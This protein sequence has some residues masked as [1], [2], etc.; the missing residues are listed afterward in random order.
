M[1]KQKTDHERLYDL[2]KC[3]EIQ[4]SID[5]STSTFEKQVKISNG[6]KIN[7]SLEYLIQYLIDK[8]VT[9]PPEKK[10]VDKAMKSGRIKCRKC[11]LIKECPMGQRVVAYDKDFTM[12]KCTI[13]R[14]RGE[15][16]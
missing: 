10:T 11:D 12:G 4:E 14:V 3:A 1:L 9:L 15:D 2:I 13:G 6:E 8:G 5:F 7:C 16:K